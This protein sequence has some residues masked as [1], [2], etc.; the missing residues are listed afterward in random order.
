LLAEVG[1]RIPDGQA[2]EVALRNDGALALTI[3]WPAHLQIG[4]A[5][6]DTLAGVTPSNARGRFVVGP[7]TAGDVV[8]LQFGIEKKHPHIVHHCGIFGLTGQGKS[9]FMK[10][11]L[12]QLCQSPGAEIIIIDWKGG[13][14]V[15]YIRNIPGQV[16]PVVVAD[17][18]QSR[19]ALQYATLECARRNRGVSD[20]HLERYEGPPLYVCIS[21]FALLTAKT[22]GAADAPSI[23]ML[24]Y[25][26]MFGRSAG[27]HLIMDTQYAS[28]DNFGS[29]VIRNMLDFV[30]CYRTKNQYDTLAALPPGADVRPYLTL[31]QPGDGYTFVDGQGRRT[32]SAYVRSHKLAEIIDSAEPKLRTWAT[33]D[34]SRLEGLGF[35][36]PGERG[37]PVAEPF[38]AHD[39][40]TALGVLRGK[41]T[42]REVL[43]E[44]LAGMGSDRADELLDLARELDTEMQERGICRPAEK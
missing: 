13:D 10:S 28:V 7:D 1:W 29:P 32:L 39:I 18:D 6:L 40:A 3:P 17:L 35:D 5:P 23:F 25:L 41:G 34:A 37:R 4:D 22:I 20:N 24:A 12:W 11:L 36:G 19:A 2:P 14:G 31:T 21:E 16:G 9:Y 33:Y 43:R 8:T 30:Q 38:S 26:A 15:N 42:K 27:V 44:R